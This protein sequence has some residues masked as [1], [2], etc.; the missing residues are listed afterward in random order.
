MELRHLE[1]F[2]A[3]VEEHGFTRAA[4]RLC[5]V[6]SA[7]SAGIRSLERELGARLLHRT[8]REI[9]LTEAGEAFLPAARETLAGAQRAVDAVDRTRGGLR[10]L[11]RI[12]TMNT[13]GSI[14]LPRVLGLLRRAHPQVVV[15]LGT[16]PGGSRDLV[17]A[18][19]LGELDIAVLSI[20]GPPPPGLLINPLETLPMCVLAPAGHSLAG[21]ETV[22][23]ADLA[24]EVFIDHPAGYGSRTVVDRAFED[25]GITRHVALEV[26]GCE[27][28]ADYVREGLGVAVVPAPATA[29]AGVSRLLIADAD[30]QWQVCVARSRERAASAAA[31]ALETMLLDHGSSSN[32]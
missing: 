16:R 18:L 31:L 22:R 6:Q 32:S 13:V 1:Y 15:R 11:L 25:S 20:G 30:L 4:A 7:V 9:G 26:G 27:H 24:G 14:D 28:P 29:S 8:S 3:V 21:Q 19:Q 5:V 10:G 2:V 23:L 17:R 12:G